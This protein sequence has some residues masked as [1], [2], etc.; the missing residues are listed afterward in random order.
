MMT[1]AIVV[2]GM[3]IWSSLDDIRI[4]LKYMNNLKEKEQF[5][6][7]QYDSNSEQ[8]ERSVPIP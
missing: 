3:F 8:H 1:L 5:K 7:K 2:V 6:N 4:E